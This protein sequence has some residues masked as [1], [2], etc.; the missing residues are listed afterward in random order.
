MATL[1][2][3]GALFLLLLLHL[4]LL[5]REYH[6]ATV[7]TEDAPDVALVVASTKHENTSWLLEYFP[8][9]QHRIYVVD[10][11]QAALTVP[12][13]KGREAMV[14]LTY[15]ID[16]YD[17]L[18]ANMLFLHA[19]RFQWHNDDPDYDGLALL[20]RFRFAY[21]RQRGY[22]NLRCVWVIGCPVEIRPEEVRS[23][24]S[25]AE[26]RSSSAENST[27]DIFKTA[28]QELLPDTPVPRAVGVSCCAQFAVTRATVRRRPRAEYVRYRA[29][30]ERSELDDAVTGRVFEYLWHVI[31]GQD[32]IHCPPAADCYCNVYGRCGLACPHDG[33]CERQYSLPPY[34]TLPEGW[35]RVGWRGEQRD[36]A[37][38]L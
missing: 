3:L 20:R 14:Y 18:P 32:P 8:R 30:L 11:A 10:D 16:H 36:F 4:R 26:A 37:G 9:W 27:A 21:L 17:R 24:E 6:T 2:A 35:P 25:S 34:A 19:Q 7:P 33:R 15:I 13:N 5:D 28:F 22:V 12:R 29:W 31:F 38:P 1:G 23:A